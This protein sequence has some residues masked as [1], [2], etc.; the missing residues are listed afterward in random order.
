MMVVPHAEQGNRCEVR[1]GRLA[2]DQ[3]SIGAELVGGVLEQPAG[4]GV[5]VI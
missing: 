2:T 5:A 1:P 4:R 3:Q